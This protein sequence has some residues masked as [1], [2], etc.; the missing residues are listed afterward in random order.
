MFAALERTSNPN[1]ALLELLP[2]KVARRLTLRGTSR[3]M[4]SLVDYLADLSS[5]PY[6]YNV[7]LSHQ[8]NNVQNNVNDIAFEVRMQINE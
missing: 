5:E 7:Y 3:D 1:I 4:K 8:K 2:D 6:F